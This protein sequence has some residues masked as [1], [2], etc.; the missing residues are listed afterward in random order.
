MAGIKKEK[1][2]RAKKED[3]SRGID[4]TEETSHGDQRST[5]G[6]GSTHSADLDITLAFLVSCIV[7]Q[8]LSVIVW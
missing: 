8:K 6:K 7:G 5:P 3:E 4:K 2:E 1:E